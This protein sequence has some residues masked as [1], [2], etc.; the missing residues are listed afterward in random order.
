MTTFIY[1]FPTIKKKQ[2]KILY[3]FSRS[4]PRLQD[5]TLSSQIQII[6]S[7]R[8]VS[9]IQSVVI[10][11][12]ANQIFH[13]RRKLAFQAAVLS[14]PPQFCIFTTTTFPIQAKLPNKWL[15]CPF[16]PLNGQAY[17]ARNMKSRNAIAFVLMLNVNRFA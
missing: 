11:R 13:Q 16:P 2:K 3:T 17:F 5:Y 10:Y 7:L 14:P 9:P 6:R 15:K 4:I 8:L 1:F 12:N